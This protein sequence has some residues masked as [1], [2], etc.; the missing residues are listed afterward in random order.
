MA[1]S[2]R[3]VVDSGSP[4]NISFKSNVEASFWKNEKGSGVNQEHPACRLQISLRNRNQLDS[5]GMIWWQKKIPVPSSQHAATGH[6]LMFSK[7]S[8]K[9]LGHSQI[10]YQMEFITA[11]KDPGN[12]E[13]LKNSW[14][15]KGHLHSS[16]ESRESW[17]YFSNARSVPTF[18][19][20][21]HLSTW[22]GNID[23]RSHLCH[24]SCLISA[25]A[26]QVN[27][28]AAKSHEGSGSVGLKQCKIIPA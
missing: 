7:F 5:I 14:I 4:I 15:Q 3:K 17:I 24:L 25:F 9:F 21:K 8:S 1:G 27:A 6:R 12:L 19:A 11:K 22:F 16:K 13:K 23:F 28:F 18:E 10:P 2:W 26:A 20:T